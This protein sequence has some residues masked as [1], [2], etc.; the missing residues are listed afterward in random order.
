[1]PSRPSPIPCPPCLRHS[2]SKTRTPYVFLWSSL[3]RWTVLVLL[4]TRPGR[5]FFSN[6]RLRRVR[7]G[8]SSNLAVQNSIAKITYPWWLRPSIG[9][10]NSGRRTRSWCVR[11]IPFSLYFISSTV[12][13][14][15]TDHTQKLYEKI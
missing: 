14:G 13:R 12:C 3:I 1:M 5:L 4:S 15:R 8:K 7:V 10:A 2:N 9:C 6:E 11:S